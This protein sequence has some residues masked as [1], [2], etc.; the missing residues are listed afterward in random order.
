MQQKVLSL[1]FYLPIW[2]TEPGLGV[3][4]FFCY[5]LPQ[6][7]SRNRFTQTHRWCPWQPTG[8]RPT[9]HELWAGSRWQAP[10]R[11]SGRSRARAWQSCTWCPP[12]RGSGSKDC[13]LSTAEKVKRSVKM[14]LAAHV[15]RQLWQAQLKWD[16]FGQ[17][18]IRK[19]N[20]RSRTQQA[21]RTTISIA[22]ASITEAI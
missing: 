4:W 12:R 20:W 15:D 6:P 21:S 16:I 3:C 10:G 1:I 22:T 13:L 14:C 5:P 18:A 2:K 19:T 8:G 11:S 7:S 17:K 9:P